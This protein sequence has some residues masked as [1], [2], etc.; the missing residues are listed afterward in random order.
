MR[1]RLVYEGELRANQRDPL[2]GQP[3]K[4]ASH[5]HSIRR[6]LHRQMQHHWQTNRFLSEHRV[7]PS[8]Y[9]MDRSASNHPAWFEPDD[10]EK[11]SLSDAVRANHMLQDL[12]FVPLV[13]RQWR[14]TCSLSILFLRHDPPGS[15][16][17]A[18]DLDNRLKTLIDCLRMPHNSREIA[19]G[20]LNKEELPLYVLLEDDDLISDLSVETDRLLKP[21]NGKTD[22]DRR[23]VHV[24]LTAD[25]K[26]ID[27]TMFNLGFAS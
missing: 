14:I 26:P 5:K 17:S 18:G 15:A 4:L 13:R 9:G 11:I 16:V 8:D 25:I 24:V 22:L 21:P 10:S 19:P 3:D 27:V 23:Q 12:E 1:L 7:Y 2:S 6:I 20:S